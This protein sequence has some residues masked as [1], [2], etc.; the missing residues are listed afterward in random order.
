[1]KRME[2]TMKVE[3]RN[4]I[5]EIKQR[6]AALQERVAELETQL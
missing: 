5:N 3:I 6:I 4:E 1:M 2:E